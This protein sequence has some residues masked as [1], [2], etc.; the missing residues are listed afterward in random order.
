VCAPRQFFLPRADGAMPS[1]AD[2]ISEI[3]QRRTWL[4]MLKHHIRFPRVTGYACA[5]SPMWVR[6]LRFPTASTSP[7]P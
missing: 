3:E 5:A 7:N 1:L 2:S 4:K 6:Q